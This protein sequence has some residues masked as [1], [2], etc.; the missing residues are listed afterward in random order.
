MKTYTF[1]FLV[2]V[3]ISCSS[4][5][6]PGIKMPIESKM[7]LTSIHIG[8]TELSFNEQN[9]LLP[10]NEP[11]VLRFNKTLNRSS[12]K[13][14]VMLL[15]ENN[16]IVDG[17]ITFL[18]EDM[19]ISFISRSPLSENETHEIII[20]E[21]LTGSEGETFQGLRIT[22]STLY[23]PLSIIGLKIA[24]KDIN[25]M[26]RI[27]DINFMPRFLIT[28]SDTIEASIIASHTLIKSSNKSF[29]FYL[30]Q[31]DERTI[32]LITTEPLNDLSKHF[33]KIDTSLGMVLEREFDGLNFSFFT[34][35]DTSPKFP[36]IDDESLLTKV[37]EKTFKYFWDFGHP[38]SGLIR[39]RNTSTETVTSGGTGFGIMVII[40]GIERGFITR[41]EGIDRLKKM[42]DFLSKA[43]RF[44]GVWPHW[45]NGK[46]GKVIPFSSKDD[47]ADLVETSYLAMGLLT[48][49]QY[50]DKNNSE[51]KQLI[52]KI[53]SLWEGIEWN[54][55]TQDNQS[56]LYWHW[57]PNF[58]WEKNL[59]ISGY[60]E[61]LITYILAAS[62]PTFS[63][64]PL[65]YHN[66]WARNGDVKNG[67]SYF[68]IDLPLGNQAYGGPLF[69]EHYTFLGI[70]PRNLKDRYSN[71]WDQ[72]VNHT[73]INRYYCIDNPKNYIGY[74]A[75]CW[76]LTASDGNNGYSAHSPTNDRGVI[77]PTAAI[78]SFP[79]TPEESMEALHYFYY[80]IGNRIWKD[81]GFVDAFNFT[82]GWVASSFLAIDQAPIIIMIENH[83]SGLLWDL[84]MSA[85]EVQLG[86][87]R[88]DFT[89]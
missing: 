77:T 14:A 38:T 46:T 19:T 50:L 88:L 8:T 22:F 57:S 23:S 16:E 84:F 34:A 79:F 80:T 86:L 66:G 25:L 44:H 49:R 63:I 76:G 39:E 81:Y 37:Q 29:S 31:V 18:D 27:Q 75:S 87:N 17:A 28:F 71:Y 33:L 4:P 9:L 65:V 45:L 13:N 6:L 32:E 59:K 74:D 60:N 3:L 41:Q 56:V 40:V 52:E 26:D 11:I 55:H 68:G 89:F 73:L 5:E 72:V 64:D 62:S 43:D 42:I 47:G 24:D 54:W 51:E 7:Q 70:D 10:I 36:K 53:T 69:F 78:S 21:A 67:N 30:E 58:E 83:R 2:I 20:T 61:A 15:D 35:L 12:V 1:F 48:A 85:P 82:E